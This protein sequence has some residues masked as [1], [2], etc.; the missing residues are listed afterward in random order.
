M[1]S[2]QCQ[3]LSLYIIVIILTVL[4]NSI[5][6]VNPGK[7]LHYRHQTT[8][9]EQTVPEYFDYGD[10]LEM[11]RSY[12]HVYLQSQFYNLTS[13]P[14]YQS[15][16]RP[17]GNCKGEKSSMALAPLQV[18]MSMQLYN[19]AKVDEMTSV[20]HLLVFDFNKLTNHFLSGIYIS[21]LS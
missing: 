2:L 7:Q 13:M 14:Y 9:P 21:I 16:I 17:F 6:L 10:D 19:Y 20:W 4:H 11:S 1:K 5:A 12:D 8:V 18:N 15:W 3:S